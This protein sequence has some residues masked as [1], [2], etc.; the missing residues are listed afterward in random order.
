MKKIFAT[1]KDL[2]KNGGT[3]GIEIRGIQMRKQKKKAKCK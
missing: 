2:D 3:V 1:E